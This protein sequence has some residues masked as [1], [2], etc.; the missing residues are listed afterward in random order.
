MSF[1]LEI[2][3]VLFIAVIFSTVLAYG[4]WRKPNLWGIGWFFLLVFLCIWAF[5]IWIPP[6]TPMMMGG[7]WLSYF[8]VGILLAILLVVFYP[9]IKESSSSEVS[10]NSDPDQKEQREVVSN[11]TWILLLVLLTMIVFGYINRIFWIAH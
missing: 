9:R 7:Q 4:V 1:Y 10:R 5:A 8:L 3:M 6:F 2:F 11:F